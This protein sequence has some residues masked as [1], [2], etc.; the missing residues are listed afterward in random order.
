MLDT[1]RI[2]GVT[3]T[4]EEM[5]DILEYFY[6]EIK[7]SK[8]KLFITTPNPEM[9]VYAHRHS[10]YKDKLNSS[11]IALPDGVG[12][13]FA[14]G[15]LGKALKERIPGVDFIE[16]LCKESIDK[17]L[18]MG[19]LGAK[20]GI[21][22]QA[23]KRLL[24]R[25]PYLDIRFVASEWDESGFAWNKKKNDKHL[26]ILF[27]AFGVP[28]QEEWIYANLPSLPVKAAMGVGGSLDFLSGNVRR[29]PFLIR[30]LGL[31]WLFRLI[32]Q[33]WRWKRQLALL[34][35]IKLVLAKKD[36]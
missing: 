5:D 25:Y 1:I 35:F 3:I 18:S 22:E 17:P 27:V 26:D 34:T 28:K 11:S 14:S 4:N 6:S 29:A 19:F 30:L 15:L 10:V 24:K 20:P 21:A 2:L 23:A 32:T 36:N 8:T 7:K 31:E 9:L 16:K 33:P 12:L 13:F